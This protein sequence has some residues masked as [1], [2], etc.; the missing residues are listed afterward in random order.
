MLP[1]A[2]V[3]RNTRILEVYLMFKCS[4]IYILPFVITISIIV[5]IL[6]VLD[7]EENVPISV[8]LM[9]MSQVIELIISIQEFVDLDRT[10]IN[11]ATH[12]SKMCKTVVSRLCYY[13]HH[14]VLLSRYRIIRHTSICICYLKTLFT[15]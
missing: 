2:R 14:T 4:I 5:S 11:M 1:V 10:K 13:Y 3:A 15:N 8:T 7:D 6:Y 12:V 9:L